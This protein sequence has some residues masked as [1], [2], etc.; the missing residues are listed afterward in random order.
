MFFWI[1]LIILVI[2]TV[3]SYLLT[4]RPKTGAPQPSALGDFTLPTAQ[5][6]RIVPVIYG[7]VKLAGGNC[8][9]WGDLQITSLSEHHQIYAYMYRLGI[10]LALCYGGE[11]GAEVEFI[12]FLADD[13][14][15][16]ITSGIDSNDVLNIWVRAYDFFGGNKQEGGVAGTIMFYNGHPANDP[17]PQVADA[18]LARIQGRA[19][20]A[21]RGICHAVFVGFYV[22][23]SSYVKTL[24]FILKRC[25]NPFGYPI[26]A[27]DSDVP[28]SRR[29]LPEDRGGRLRGLVLRSSGRATLLVCRVAPVRRDGLRDDQQARRSLARTRDDPG[30]ARKYAASEHEV[31]SRR[32]ARGGTLRLCIFR[33]WRRLALQARSGRLLHRKRRQFDGRRGLVPRSAVCAELCDLRRRGED[34][35]RRLE[36]G[37]HQRSTSRRSISERGRIASRS[38]LRCIAADSGST[39]IP[40]VDNGGIIYV[41]SQDPNQT[42]NYVSVSNGTSFDGTPVV[43]NYLLKTGDDNNGNP[44]LSAQGS[45]HRR[46]LR[47]GG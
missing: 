36:R 5:A 7:T 43:T 17:K 19:V 20:P 44:I 18:Y 6:G 45:I 39:A 13:K 14:I 38:D 22:G 32:S 27:R 21:Y 25:P 26:G 41:F 11:R 30:R 15:V 40:V 12:S 24:G 42:H 8:T 16:P 47:P 9:Y 31:R 37:D 34:H 46:D 35:F 23:T 3:A 33:L 28:R 1:M 2:T 10:Q 29:E 4:P